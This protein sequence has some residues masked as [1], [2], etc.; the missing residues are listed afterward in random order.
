[1]SKNAILNFSRKLLQYV[2]VKT[3][4]VTDPF[5][6]NPHYDFSLRNTILDPKQ[7]AM[8]Q[9][10]YGKG[11]DHACRD[12]IISNVTDRFQCQYIMLT[13]PTTNNPSMLLIGPFTYEV[14][15][16]SRIVE[17]CNLA[18]IPGHLT[19]FMHE[20]Y[21]SLPFVADERWIKGLVRN[22][23]E[24]LWDNPEDLQIKTYRD[25][26]M[27]KERYNS[28]HPE[29]N[30]DAISALENSYQ[31]EELLM[32]AI[33]AGDLKTIENIMEDNKLPSLKQRFSD[34]IRDK[35]NSLIILNTLCR[36]AAQAGHVHPVYLDE[37]F[38]KYTLKIESAGSQQQLNAIPREMFR[39]YCFLVQS[40]SLNGYSQPIQKA[41]NLISFNLTDDLTLSALSEKLCLNSSYLST[42]FKK[43]TGMTL[44]H[45]VNSKRV[46][47]A[48]YLLNTTTLPIQDIAGLCGISDLNY[49]TKVFK[50]N[51]NM[52]PT[53]YREMLRGH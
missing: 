51:Q 1:M 11:F 52:T 8:V 4:V 45:Y 32:R 48:I 37:M 22:L 25:E 21:S 27:V 2:S 53:E 6:W 30:S 9:Q 31:N 49:F 42:L 29:S 18:S 43:E 3:N 28:L 7:M 34:S 24:E 38:S 44:T 15:T 41:I 26:H 13:L 33:A 35:K 36:K 19:N 12:N 47:H 50:K 17:L 5:T 40:H 10:I 20:Y 14:M 46:E 16:A 39:K 23:A